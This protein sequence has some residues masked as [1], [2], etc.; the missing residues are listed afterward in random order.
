MERTWFCLGWLNNP[1][2]RP[3]S[4]DVPS[5]VSIH[6]YICIHRLIVSHR[7]VAPKLWQLFN[8]LPCSTNHVP[9]A[10]TRHSRPFSLGRVFAVTT[11]Q[12]SLPTAV[13]A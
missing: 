2:P 13:A 8:Y 1:D 4:R 5:P 3:C 7:K 9:V 11:S 10:L 12:N 6:H